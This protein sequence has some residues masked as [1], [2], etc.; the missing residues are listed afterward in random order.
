MRYM[1]ERAFEKLNE[2]TFDPENNPCEEDCAV[3]YAAFQKGDQLKRLPCKHE[4]H[5]AC[6]KKWYGE[7]DTCP[8]CRKRIY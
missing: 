6:I 2:I 8:M 5:T 1:K 7:R 4:F 3:C